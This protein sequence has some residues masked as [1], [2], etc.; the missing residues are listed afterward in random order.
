M[1]ART[2]WAKACNR[3]KEWSA[4]SL[5]HFKF[6]Y[7]REVTFAHAWLDTVEGF[8]KTFVRN[9]GCLLYTLDLD[10]IFLPAGF[11]NNAADFFNFCGEGL[12][13]SS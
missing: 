5:S 12:F 1:V 9:P 8:K 7:A 4:A 10:G 3:F 11:F 6:E 2:I 13:L